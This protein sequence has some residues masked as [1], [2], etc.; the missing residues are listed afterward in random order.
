MASLAVRDTEGMF[1]IIECRL[2]TANTML[3]CYDK[4][5][6]GGTTTLPFPTPSC[7]TFTGVPGFPPAASPIPT[8]IEIPTTLTPARGVSNNDVLEK[9]Q[10]DG[11]A[12]AVVGQD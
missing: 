6:C 1:L 10:E 5:F 11:S 2:F 12:V 7:S 4:N 9:E 8:P 3:S